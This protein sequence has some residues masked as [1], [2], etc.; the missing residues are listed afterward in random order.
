M[1]V[2]LRKRKTPPPAPVRPAKKKAAPKT[3]KAAKDAKPEETV[4]D[5]AKNAVTET[6]EAVKEAVTGNGESTSATP[7]V[8]DTITLTNFGGEVETHTGTKTTLAKLVEQS[9]SGVVLF[10]YPKASTPGCTKQVCFFRDSYTPLTATGFDIYGLS[11]DSPKSNT[12]FATKQNLPY[13]LLCDPSRTLI[14]AIGLKGAKG[15]TRGI[16]IVDKEGKVLAA[17]PGSPEG[18]VEVARK[19]LVK[20]MEGEEG[21]GEKKEEQATTAEEKKEVAETAAEVA[22]TAEKLDEGKA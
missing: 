3:S 13:P 9:K 16:F 7:K 4:V 10:T 11:N 20:E 22:D 19:I 1:P 21:E 17:E 14:S 18:T 15:T 2:E 6:V 5:K 12:T 8:G